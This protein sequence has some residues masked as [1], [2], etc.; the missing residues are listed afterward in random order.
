MRRTR[1][2]RGIDALDRRGD[3]ALVFFETLPA[4]GARIVLDACVYI[5]QLQDRLPAPIE[6]R[7]LMRP[8][9]HS[10]LVL[11]EL[12]YTLGRLDPSDSRTKA[13]SHAI[14]ALLDSIPPAR[15]LTPTP[16]DQAEGAIAAGVMARKLGYNEA[17]RRKALLDAMLARQ[18]A[19][20]GLCLV[21]RN[22]G[23]FDRLSQLDRR[24]QVA[25]YRR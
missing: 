13:H 25:F 12:S 15:I 24:L 17:D 5:D 23:D 18:A 2:A 8:A 9:S 14:V 6:E 7:V 16:E 11:A 1:A 3:H 21:T 22:V 19:R 4:V 10:S 20:E